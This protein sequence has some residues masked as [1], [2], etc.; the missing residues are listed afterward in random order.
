MFQVFNVRKLFHCF[1]FPDIK[2]YREWLLPATCK[3]HLNDQ[4]TSVI[5]NTSSNTTSGIVSDRVQSLDESEDDL[6]V[7][8]MIT[9]PPAPSVESLALAHLRDGPSPIPKGKKM[10][11][12]LNCEKKISVM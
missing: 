6:E 8:I 10:S 1:T 4:R 12:K 9:S 2:R 7:E 3:T 5:S 11:I